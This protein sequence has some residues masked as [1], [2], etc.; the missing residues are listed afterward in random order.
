M[1]SYYKGFNFGELRYGKG[2]KSHL[3]ILHKY[4]V[5]ETQGIRVQFPKVKIVEIDSETVTLDF[6]ERGSCFFQRLK[7]LNTGTI[8]KKLRPGVQF[9]SL[10]SRISMKIN[11][12]TLYFTEENCITTL[13]DIR[14]NSD[15]VRVV[16]IASSDGL[17]LSENSYGNTWTVDQMKIY[18]R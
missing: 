14:S 18:P 4:F 13:N 15:H 12:S 3:G 2:I 1:V 8:P 10:S 17:W 7:E 5:G 9:N 16:V 6:E 11:D